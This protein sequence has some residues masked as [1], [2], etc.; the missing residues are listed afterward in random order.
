MRWSPGT[1]YCFSFSSS[2]DL[3]YKSIAFI[4]GYDAISLQYLWSK[5]G[6][7]I[8]VTCS[9]A[10]YPMENNYYLCYTKFLNVKFVFAVMWRKAKLLICVCGK[11]NI[12]M[13]TAYLDGSIS[14]TQGVDFCRILLVSCMCRTSEWYSI[15]RRLDWSTQCKEFAV[16]HVRQYTCH[17]TLKRVRVTS[18]T[19][20]K[21]E[22]MHILS[23]CL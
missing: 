7:S 19:V 5:F 16:Y 23:M 15:G 17:V 21:Q 14:H 4:L 12:F 18:V 1:V 8:G 9:R 22:V 6:D 10:E 20:E 3:D 11:R 13:T 2:F